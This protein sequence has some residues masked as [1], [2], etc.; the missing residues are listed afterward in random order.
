MK[1]RS[2]PYDLAVEAVETMVA[3]GLAGI[4]FLFAAAD[5]AHARAAR[6]PFD[7]WLDP[8]RQCRPAGI[9]AVMDDERTRQGRR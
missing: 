8:G 6:R 9:R 3:S 2:K 4:T 7:K 5:P 1:P